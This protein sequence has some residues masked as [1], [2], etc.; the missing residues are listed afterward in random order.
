METC[1]TEEPDEGNPHVRICGGI[2]RAIADSTWTQRT[3]GLLFWTIARTLKGF[4]NSAVVKPL[5]GLLTRL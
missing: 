2:G 5:Q 1:G 4:N 3:V